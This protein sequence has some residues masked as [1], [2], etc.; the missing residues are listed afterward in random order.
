MTGM[1]GAANMGGSPLLA[2]ADQASSLLGLS[3]ADANPVSVITEKVGMYLLVGGHMHCTVLVSVGRA[4]AC[5]ALQPL[6][7]V[8]QSIKTQAGGLTDPFSPSV[9]STARRRLHHPLDVHHP[10]RDRLPQEGT[11]THMYVYTC[12]HTYT[13][14][15]THTHTYTQ[16]GS[17]E[18][19]ALAKFDHG[20]NLRFHGT[21]V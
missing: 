5:C 3:L 20:Y 6:V 12:I 17:G 16:A 18:L 4:D 21:C 11:D 13:H 10:P 1:L 2:I 9:N 14:V 19:E 8:A 7:L 15:F